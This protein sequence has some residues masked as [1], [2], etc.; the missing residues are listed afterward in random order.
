V[1]FSL[2]VPNVA[3]Q[4]GIDA[5]GVQLNFEGLALAIPVKSQGV[6]AGSVLPFGGLTTGVPIGFLLCDGA[7]YSAAQYA[8]LFNA[9]RYDF[10]GSGALFNVPSL[11]G[12]TINSVVLSFII[13]I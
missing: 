10:G 7:S 3:R 4:D 6:P 1:A 11:V 5:L 2:P 13:K 9:I 8:A 12:G